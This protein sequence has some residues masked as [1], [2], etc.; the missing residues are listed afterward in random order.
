MCVLAFAWRAD[1]RWPLVLIGNRDERHD[2]PA[3]ALARWDEAPH[4]IA[5]RDVEAGGTWLGVSEQ[6]RMA[7]VTNLRNPDGPHPDRAS[8]GQLVADLLTGEGRYTDPS[9]AAL[10]DFNPFNLID[11]RA[12]DARILTNRP[13]RA[14]RALDRGIHGMSNGALDEH[15][16]KVDRIKAL[17][18]DWIGVGTGEARPLLDALRADAAPLSAPEDA[19]GGPIFILNPVYGTRCSTVVVVDADGRG[20]IAERRYDAQGRETGESTIAFAWAHDGE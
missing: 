6:G 15:W 19:P 16:P 5:G 2:R 7:V 11:L 12:G 9:E 4:V 1:P 14:I 17:L 10:A 13:A 20:L 8:R 3:E 18:E